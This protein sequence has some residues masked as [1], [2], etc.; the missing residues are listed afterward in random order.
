MKMAFFD[1]I[2]LP[3]LLQEVLVKLNRITHFEPLNKVS[4][5]SFYEVSKETKIQL[6]DYFYDLAPVNGS[7]K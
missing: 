2:S 6:I 1:L 5:G 7:V 3:I 4:G